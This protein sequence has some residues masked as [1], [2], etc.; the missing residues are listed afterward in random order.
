MWSYI[1]DGLLIL[2]ILICAIIGIAKGLF[3][4]LISLV[5]TGLALAISVFTAKYV[6]NFINKIFNFEDFILKKLYETDITNGTILDGFENVEIAKFCVWICS[7]VIMFLII[8]LAIRILARFFESVTKASP[9]ISGMNRV[10]GMVFGI[11]KGGVIVI[12]SLALCS[13]V[14]QVPNI[15][16]KVYDAINSTKI[17][18]G[19]Y[20]YVDEFVEKNLTKDKIQEIV[21]KIVSDNKPSQD[22]G[23]NTGNSETLTITNN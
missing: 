23:S 13:L 9:T 10:L 21:D 5:G 2:I 17:T 20:K 14:T 18:S 22:Q 1:I 19:V 16:T 15:G 8:R 6:S 3:D 7:I 12:A 11:I 4:S